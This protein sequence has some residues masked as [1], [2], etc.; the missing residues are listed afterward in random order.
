MELN[1]NLNWRSHVDKT[2]AKANK[3]SAFMYRTIRGCPTKVHS[4]CYRGLVRPIME[5]S[6]TVWDTPTSETPGAYDSLEKVQRRSARRIFRDFRPTTSASDLVRR[7][8]L[9][10]LSDRRIVSRSV[11]MYKVIHGLVD[12]KPK[13]GVITH[14]TRPSRGQP[15]KIKELA[16]SIDAYHDSFFPA[17]IRTWNKLPAQVCAVDTPSA[18]KRNV[19]GWVSSTR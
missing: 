5:Y 7:L 19:E 14:N 11:M 6:A 18:F 4:T 10:R 15:T 9:P 17:T 13:E 1:K 12:L 3:I 8:N 16:T 2:A